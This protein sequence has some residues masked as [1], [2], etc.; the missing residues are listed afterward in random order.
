M[1]S[2]R[3]IEKGIREAEANISPK[4]LIGP[5]TGFITDE[6]CVDPQIHCIGCVRV[7]GIFFHSP[8]WAEIEGNDSDDPTDRCVADVWYAAQGNMRGWRILNPKGEIFDPCDKSQPSLQEALQ[9][10]EQATIGAIEQLT[11]IEWLDQTPDPTADPKSSPLTQWLI[12]IAAGDVIIA[13]LVCNAKGQ[14][15]L[16]NER[17]RLIEERPGTL[18]LDYQPGRSGSPIATNAD[19]AALEKM[20]GRTV[21]V[22]GYAQNAEG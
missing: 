17:P 11:T 9:T 16:N 3:E 10:A 20:T 18:I 21:C 22:V 14:R 6:D 15:P 7:E 4:S 19:Y 13:E 2:E 12:R 5:E 1:N 8:Q